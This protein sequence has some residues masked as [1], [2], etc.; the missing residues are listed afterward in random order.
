MKRLYRI[1][2]LLTIF[3]LPLA[4]LAQEQQFANLGDF[5]LESG[6][7]LRDCRI[8]YRLAGRLNADK[9]NIILLPTWAGGTTEQLLGAVGPGKLADSSKYYVILVDA[10]SNSVSSS[11]S[12]STAQPHMHFPKITIL[13][14]VTTQHEL[15]TK[16]LHIE[17]VKAV[18]GVS[19]GGMQ[20]FQWLVSYPDFMDKAI[21]IVGS[22]R[23]AAFDLLH[24]QTQI[25]AIETDPA[26][27]GG[28][29]TRNPARGAEFEFGAILLTTPE[30]F[31][32]VTKREDVLAEIE[33]A[34]TSGGGSDANDKIRQSQA[35]MAIDVSKPF[36]GSLERAA[37]AV[38]AQVLVITSKQ[39][40]TVTPGPATAFAHLLHAELLELDSDCGHMAPSCEGAK[41]QK[42]VAEF[43]E[44]KRHRPGSIP[45]RAHKTPSHRTREMAA[46]LPAAIAAPTFLPRIHRKNKS[47]VCTARGCT[48]RLLIFPRGKRH[49]STGLV[50]SEAPSKRDTRQ[51]LLRNQTPLSR[52]GGCLC[53]T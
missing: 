49:G 32:R 52:L 39:D 21:P 3:L 6:A 35:M 1:A 41:V 15:L 14:M 51:T 23:L 17:H 38:K 43:L 9:S 47:E 48:I 8:G 29:Y 27:Q 13:D 53:L 34:K 11:P 25:D 33:K 4:A 45:S 24:W 18:M 19:M 30:H 46:G 50:E 16:V 5:E 44:H 36:D 2:L 12:N 26:W 7:I 37:A 22:P 28:D 42:A 10:L 31:N 20:T 40:H